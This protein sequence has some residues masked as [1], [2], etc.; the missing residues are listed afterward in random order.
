MFLYP[1]LED[2]KIAACGVILN[3]FA[4]RGLW[5]SWDEPPSNR[6]VEGGGG[7]ETS[8]GSNYTSQLNSQ[9]RSKL[10]D[11]AVTERKT[12]SK[13]PGN[14]PTAGVAKRSAADTMSKVNASRQ[15]V[16][17]IGNRNLKTSRA[18]QNDEDGEILEELFNPV[19]ATK[20]EEI[21]PKPASSQQQ[22]NITGYR[23][24]Q[25]KR[26]VQNDEEGEILG[27]LLNPHT[28]R[29]AKRSAEEKNPK[30]TS[31]RMQVFSTENGD[32][33]SIRIAKYN[34][35]EILEELFS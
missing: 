17:T 26:D 2:A 25:T 12:R 8:H 5:G 23:D 16:N 3:S 32:S 6:M 35:G 31:S 22:V 30:P 24:S 11:E 1:T 15:Q 9:Q 20:V 14:Q 18:V 10:S 29:A 4:D 34:E 19:T 27:Q 13:P 21:Q 7:R 33:Q 28:V